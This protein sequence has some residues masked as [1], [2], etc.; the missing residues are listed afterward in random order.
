MENKYFA[1]CND[2]DV[3]LTFIE[4]VWGGK[5]RKRTP[6]QREKD[7]KAIAPKIKELLNNNVKGKDIRQLFN[8]NNQDYYKIIHE[9]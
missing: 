7:L 1:M 2:N 3:L 9:F 6:E 5:K 4:Y 8:L